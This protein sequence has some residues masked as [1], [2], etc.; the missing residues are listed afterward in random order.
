VIAVAYGEGIMWHHVAQISLFALALLLCNATSRA[1]DTLTVEVIRDSSSLPHKQ[2]PFTSTAG[3]IKQTLEGLGYFDATPHMLRQT[4]VEP[5]TL[6]TM[7]YTQW[8]LTNRLMAKAWVARGVPGFYVPPI[9]YPDIEYPDIENT[10][11]REPISYIYFHTGQPDIKPP[12]FNN[13]QLVAPDRIEPNIDIPYYERPDFDLTGVDP[14]ALRRFTTRNSG[15]VAGGLEFDD[16]LKAIKVGYRRLPG[17]QFRSASIWDYHD[18]PNDP[19]AGDDSDRQRERRHAIYRRANFN[20]RNPRE[21]IDPKDPKPSYA[22][23]K[24]FV[25]E[26]RVIRYPGGF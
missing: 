19:R 12:S 1:A 16:K 22:I 10:N 23:R 6:A 4:T 9:E 3:L 20:Y 25:P 15:V 17:G 8:P 2:D 5:A 7:T 14:L 18:A 11:E 26:F 24:V 13:G 21:S